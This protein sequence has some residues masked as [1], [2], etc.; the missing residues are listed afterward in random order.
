MISNWSLPSKY[1]Y[2]YDTPVQ[3]IRHSNLFLS[4]LRADAHLNWLW[5]SM[6]SES[7][8]FFCQFQWSEGWECHLRNISGFIFG[9]T[10]APISLW[11]SIRRIKGAIFQIF[12]KKYRK[13]WITT[14]S[15][16][17]DGK[18]LQPLFETVVCMHKATALIDGS[19][20][21]L[22]VFGWVW[23]SIQYFKR[24][25]DYFHKILLRYFMSIRNINK[26]L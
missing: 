9:S 13:I 16:I 25:T 17:T 24:W 5:T 10:T 7:D 6:A 26:F 8:V 22:S 21:T 4:H 14:L 11:N 2:F 23:Q 3:H 19:N 1:S 12:G 15:G 18:H 20:T